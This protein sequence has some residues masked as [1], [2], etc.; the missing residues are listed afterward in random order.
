MGLPETWTVA[1]VHAEGV[2]MRGVET[3]HSPKGVLLR[4]CSDIQCG[5]MSSVWLDNTAW[6]GCSK[7]FVDLTM[8]GRGGRE[9]LLRSLKWFL[10]GEV[11]RVLQEGEGGTA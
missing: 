11:Y 7:C 1:H 5:S 3:S 10:C 2:G 9:H 8:H 4:S 6:Q